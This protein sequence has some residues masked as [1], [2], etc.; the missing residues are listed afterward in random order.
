MV[1]LKQAAVVVGKFVVC[2]IVL[3]EIVFFWTIL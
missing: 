3:I 2:V 1:T